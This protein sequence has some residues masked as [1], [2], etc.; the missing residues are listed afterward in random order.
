VSSPTAPRT[1]GLSCRC[2]SAPVRAN[3]R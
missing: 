3:D 2:V 1:C